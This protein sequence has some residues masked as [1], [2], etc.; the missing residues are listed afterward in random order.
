MGN[1]IVADID[2]DGIP[3]TSTTAFNMTLTDTASGVSER[4]RGFPIASADTNYVAAVIND[5]DGGSQLARVTA[6]T[7]PRPVRSEPS[8]S[9]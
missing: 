7:A 6:T 2:Y 5:P 9:T 1:G 3:S 4:F 8:P